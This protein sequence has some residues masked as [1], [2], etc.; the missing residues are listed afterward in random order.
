M[1]ELL[2]IIPDETLRKVENADSS[3]I[4]DELFDDAVDTCL[5][6]PPVVEVKK[7]T[8]EAAVVSQLGV[9]GLRAAMD[10]VS[11][12]AIQTPRS[13]GI[14]A[15]TPLRHPERFSDATDFETMAKTEAL[16]EGL[17]NEAYRCLGADVFARIE[18]YR[19]AE[20]D[21]EQI[22]VIEWLHT[23]LQA[24]TREERT[25]DNEAEKAFYH[26]ARLSPKFIG[27]YP[28]HR[29]P[30]TCL[31]VSII[32]A[33]FLHQVGAEQLHAGVMKTYPEHQAMEAVMFL[34]ELPK[35]T[36]Q[37]YGVRWPPLLLESLRNTAVKT[38]SQ[39]HEDRGYHAAV[40]TRLMSGRWV[41]IDPNLNAST[42]LGEKEVMTLD[43]AFSHLNEFMDIAP[44][45]ELTIPSVSLGTASGLA[46]LM[47][48]TGD[49][50][51]LGSP[52]AIKEVLADPWQESIPQ[53]IKEICVDPFFAKDREEHPGLN[54]LWLQYTETESHDGTEDALTDGFYAM[55]E[56]YVLH[57]Q[58]IDEVLQRCQNDEAFLQ[59][60]LEDA[61]T[62]PLM[63]AAWH[64][65]QGV[66]YCPKIPN[67]ITFEVGLPA[68]RIG[69]AVLNDFASYCDD[70][71]PPSYRLSHWA[72]HVPITEV[73]PDV[74]RSE[75]QED[76][77][78]NNAHWLRT[79]LRYSKDHG[80]IT[81]FLSSQEKRQARSETKE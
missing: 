30:P 60:F 13:N 73:I 41:Q 59:R 40:M 61:Q 68:M 16:G 64:V 44:G 49:E 52:E 79:G 55:F 63:V 28:D 42:V 5:S 26:P 34:A 54:E 21:D 2:S 81:S 10:L 71:L 3:R 4:F 18:A 66:K 38:I 36:Y 11:G 77:T 47:I 1:A 7:L 53:R 37:Q 6:A 43:E 27:V 72:S 35:V 78:A 33:S 50:S 46:R 56:K 31:G 12:A 76:I 80:I 32:G 24:L 48:Q 15:D 75:L 25:D 29:L 58:P 62:L 22:Q 19:N 20:S 67:H 39:V 9:R 45:L 69:S 17:L 51:L 70:Q 8:G 65:T 14:E 23:R 74:S 57:S